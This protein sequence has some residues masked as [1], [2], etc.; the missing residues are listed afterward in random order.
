[1]IATVPWLAVALVT[2]SGSPSGSLSFASTSIRTEL[3][4]ATVAL[5]LRA[6]GGGLVTSIWKVCV[7]DAFD[8]SVALTTTV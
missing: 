8:G 1:L 3:S 4:S 7:A 2:V 5:S 6:V